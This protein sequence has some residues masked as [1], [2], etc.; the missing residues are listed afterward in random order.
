MK[1]GGFTASV[2][3]YK[4]KLKDVIVT[5]PL[6]AMVNT[7]FPSTGGNTCA[8]NAALAARFT[9]STGPCTAATA[10]TAISRV[11]TVL[12]NG[13]SVNNSGIDF[14]AGYRSSD[15]L[16]SGL[17]FGIGASATYTIENRISAISVAGTLVAAGY[18][19][20][21]L[22]N[23]QTTLYPVPEWKGQGYLELGGGP[24]DARVSVNYI[25]GLYDQRADITTAGDLRAERGTGRCPG[26]WRR[27]HQQLHHGRFHGAG[28][29][30]QG[31]DAD[32]HGHQPVRQGPA[33]RPRRLQL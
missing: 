24:V 33:V 15:F 22:L 18:D 23:Y 12:Q 6:L 13:A 4:Y 25:D 7:L 3:Y 31:T 11:K 32:R 26:H 17:R 1:A 9:F 19:G 28:A 8:A 16:N 5:D 21:G 20:V 14:V 10:R 29:G 27:E 30:V 2:D